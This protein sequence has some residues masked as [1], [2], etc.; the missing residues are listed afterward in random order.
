M[1]NTLF[2]LN[3]YEDNVQTEMGFKN[4][5][6]VHHGRVARASQPNYNNTDRVQEYS[7]HNILFLKMKG[8][9]CIISANHEG[10][11]EE[12]TRK[13]AAANIAHHH[14]RVEDFQPPT[15]AQLQNAANMI[16]HVTQ[17]GGAVLVHCGYGQGRTGTFVAAWAMLKCFDGGDGKRS[18]SRD[19]MC[20]LNFLRT[21]F[22]VET[23]PQV[24]AI[25]TAAGL[26]AAA[27]AAMAPMGLGLGMGMTSA[28]SFAPPMAS[29]GQPVFNSGLSTLGAPVTNNAPLTFA[30]GGGGSGLSDIS[31]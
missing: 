1:P 26:G 16:Q 11:S 19:Q 5:Q 8:I 6:W 3:C 10:I 25:R 7:M 28:G 12:S 14:Y 4:F 13:L 21:N 18:L 24:N 23:Q 30:N 20:D 22:G 2:G 15:P 29:P 31:W 9:R 17:G 27:P